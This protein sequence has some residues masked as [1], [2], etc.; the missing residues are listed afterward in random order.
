[1]TIY[2]NN[3]GSES[4]SLDDF[5]RVKRIHRFVSGN[6]HEVRQLWYN[7]TGSK[8]ADISD[9]VLLHETILLTISA[10]TTNYNIF[11]QAGSPSYPVTVILTINSGV[12]VGSTST[13]SAALDTGTGWNS[14][15]DVTIINNGTVM[16]KGGAGGQ[17]GI[18]ANGASSAGNGSTGS[19]G[20]DAVNIQFDVKFDNQGVIGGGGG[21]GGG[22]GST[23]PVYSDNAPL[24][25]ICSMGGGGGGGRGYTSASGGAGGTYGTPPGGS[26]YCAQN[27]TSGNAGSSSSAGTGGTGVACHYP[28]GA[29][30]SDADG[31]NGGTGG[32][33]GSSGSSGATA[34]CFSG[35]T[36]GGACSVSS[37]GSGGAAGKAVD[38]NGNT[39]TWINTG[40]R[41]GAVS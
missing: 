25:Y 20:G 21:G 36:L 24:Y 5:R 30:S 34:T 6:W 9:M 18:L 26:W 32:G 40:T 37:G 2:F 39:V 19:S 4:A 7:P 15:S 14:E 27:G 31:G 28:A 35:I 41:Y 11:T 22:G 10:T 38:L 1:M 17:G 13:A 8:T 23:G 33:L 12:T 3:S 16:G 29:N